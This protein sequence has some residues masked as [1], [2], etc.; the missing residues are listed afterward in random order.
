ML[1]FKVN[2][3]L[4][5]ISFLILLPYFLTSFLIFSTSVHNGSST[6]ERIT[7][8]WMRL[9]GVVEGVNYE[10]PGLRSQNSGDTSWG[11]GFKS[12]ACVIFDSGSL[13]VIL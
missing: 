2:G 13:L 10:V 1:N 7:R 8:M 3:I 12:S 9:D 5:K 4:L 11:P 6:M